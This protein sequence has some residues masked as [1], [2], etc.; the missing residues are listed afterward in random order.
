[1]SS[2]ST[3]PGAQSDSGVLPLSSS[4]DTNRSGTVNPTKSIEK[5]PDVTKETGKK[6]SKT[7]NEPH[8]EGNC[9]GKMSRVDEESGVKTLL[10]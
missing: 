3:K 1:M 4:N 2:S 5:T 6:M 7:S 10:E 8:E 9:D